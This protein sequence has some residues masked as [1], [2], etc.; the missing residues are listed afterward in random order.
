MSYID[1]G[2][3]SSP[4]CKHFIDLE[5][6]R[7]SIWAQ[8]PC[9]YWFNYGL[10]V[11]LESAKTR[12]EVATDDVDYISAEITRVSRIGE[13]AKVSRF[14]KAVINPF[15][16]DAAAKTSAVAAKPA[17]QTYFEKPDVSPAP[18]QVRVR[19]E[20]QKQI[21]LFVAAVSMVMVALISYIAWGASVNLAA[22]I[23]VPIVASV[24]IGM[25]V[26]AVR[27]RKL[28]AT[29]STVLA[30]LSSLLAFIALW[31]L[32]FYNVWGVPGAFVGRAGAD[33]TQHFYVAAIPAI[34]GVLTLAA[35][36]RF[37]INGWLAPTSILFAVAGVIFDFSYQRSVLEVNSTNINLGW[38]LLTLTLTA[39]AIV[40]AGRP[41]KNNDQVRRVNR[42]SLLGLLAVASWH[43]LSALVSLVRGDRLD[44]LGLVVIGLVWLTLSIAIEAIG[45]RFTKSGQVAVSIRKGGW[46]L[47]LGGIGVGLTTLIVGSP[48]DPANLLETVLVWFVGAVL[49]FSPAAINRYLNDV[50][51]ELRLDLGFSSV[52]AASLAWGYWFAYDFFQNDLLDRTEVTLT[53][54][55]FATLVSAVLLAN[56]RLY[57]KSRFSVA[58][59]VAFAFAGNLLLQGRFD[60]K[61]EP[62]LGAWLHFA[63]GMVVV[64]GI[65]AYRWQRGTKSAGGLFGAAIIWF[66][67]L[68]NSLFAAPNN[69]ARTTFTAIAFSAAGVLLVSD[70]VVKKQNWSAL[71]GFVAGSIAAYAWASQVTVNWNQQILSFY[72]LFPALVLALT[73]LALKKWGPIFNVRLWSIILLIQTAFSGLI[74]IAQGSRFFAISNVSSSASSQALQ[75]WAILDLAIPL[76][77]SIGYLFASRLMILNESKTARV[78]TLV[79][80]LAMWSLG[81]AAV[82]WLTLINQINQIATSVLPA[83]AVTV[84]YAISVAATFWHSFKFASAV[85]LSAGYSTAIFLAL[86]TNDLMQVLAPTM[87][88][89]EITALVLAATLS[90]G[91]V[92]VLKNYTG[93]GGTLVTWGLPSVGLLLPSI[94]YSFTSGDIRQAWSALEAESIARLLA[95]VLVAAAMLVLGL[96]RG[97][98]GLV[99][100]GVAGLLGEFV[101]AV[102]FGIEE[103]FAGDT[104]GVV[105]ELRGLLVALTLFL[106]LTLF[107]AF[108]NLKLTSFWAW[109]VPALVALAPTVVQTIAALGGTIK[110]TDWVRFA[111]LVA[112]SSLFLLVGAIRRNSGLFYP[113]LLGVLVSVIPYAFASNGGV[114]IPIILVVLAGLIIWAA[115][116]IDRFGGWLKDLK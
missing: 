64:M 46:I 55:T 66:G 61:L 7:E 105:T 20:N 1:A 81:L 69:D 34:V 104:I 68:A 40:L 110:D 16:G 17:T 41:L 10:L 100:A 36:W 50:R 56:D 6:I 93:I 13:E 43:G 67:A 78:L 88:G 112:V 63:A 26:V 29:L 5:T 32:S 101:P 62:N 98:R 103:I 59:A 12:L 25:A 27:T 31:A 85:S 3:F 33:W 80:A 44:G 113:G 72:A 108:D 90:I 22:E 73:V 76:A 2:G 52:V 95:V 47:G 4:I 35:G 37:K 102:W 49:L 94:A 54:V 87:K 109:G 30:S 84:F 21:G 79:S 83:T 74:L 111:V 39:V 57:G 19:S 89:P 99:Y 15:R 45:D 91:S 92:I 24:V 42:L 70:A 97:N 96:R 23:Q 106:L 116:R 114:G 60:W 48:F 115:L 75:I 51:G 82:P 86:S 38:Q 18:A 53:A 71:V 65:F 11:D 9:G 14:I 58:T 107:K 8:C 77:I 28:S